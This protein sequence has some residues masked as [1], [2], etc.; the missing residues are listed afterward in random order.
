MEILG[1][2]IRQRPPVVSLYPRGGIRHVEAAAPHRRRPVLTLAGGPAGRLQRLRPPRRAGVQ[3]Q[4][5]K[6]GRNPASGGTCSEA[7]TGRPAD[8]ASTA[9]IPSP[10]NR[11]GK[12]NTSMAH[13]SRSTWLETP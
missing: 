13:S 6:Q 1:E 12:A 3:G 9:A 4:G 11:L 5:L 7:S 10:S 2:L 8:W